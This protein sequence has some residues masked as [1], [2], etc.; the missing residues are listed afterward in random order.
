L[1]DAA[2]AAIHIE[3]VRP[4]RQLAGRLPHLS[5]MSGRRLIDK[6]FFTSMQHWSGA[7]MYPAC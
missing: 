7:V 2:Y 1:R 5:V 6:R 3:N 4:I